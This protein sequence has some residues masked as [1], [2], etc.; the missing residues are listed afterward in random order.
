MRRYSIIVSIGFKIVLLIF[1]YSIFRINRAFGYE[2]YFSSILNESQQVDAVKSASDV[3]ARNG[4]NMTGLMFA[5]AE[6]M[7]SLA[8]AL[9]DAGANLDLVNPLNGNTALHYATNNVPSAKSQQVA[10]YLMD[11]FE[12]ANVK[13][14]TG[15]TRCILRGLYR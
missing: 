8:H 10:F 4:D 9:F 7:L 12:H 2:P 1:C 13:N 3:N 14:N 15:D 6:G 11:V 5:G